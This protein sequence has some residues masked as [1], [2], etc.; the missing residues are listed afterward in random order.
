MALKLVFPG[1]YALALGPVNVFLIEDGSYLTVIDAGYE[2]SEQAILDAARSL[3]KQ[4][5]DITN[6]VVTHCHPDHAG[7]L[8]ALQQ[9]TGAAVWMH[10]ADAEVVRGHQ[11]MVRSTPAPGLLNQVLF[12]VLIKNVPAQ[13]PAAV[14][15][16]EIG[17]SDLLPV[18]GGLRAIHAPGHSAGHMAF[19]LQRDG[20]ML[21]AADA[22]S[23][24]VGL[25]YSIVYDDLTEARRSL[26]KLAQEQA[27]AVCFGHGQ[28]LAGAAVRTFQRKWAL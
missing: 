15:A 12:H 2:H 17:D 6:I 4:P 7:G 16:H 20:G 25:G 9:A 14:V 11:P 8:A 21:F 26:A 22:C 19:M 28:A 24:V 18:A 13:V 27:S 1:V 10:R 23:N 3:G 5:A